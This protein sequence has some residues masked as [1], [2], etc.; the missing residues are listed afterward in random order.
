[1]RKLVFPFIAA[2]ALM[3]SVSAAPITFSETGAYQSYTVPIGVTS[4]LFDLLGASGGD[5]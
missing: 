1:M 2:A 4:I 5:G 3:A